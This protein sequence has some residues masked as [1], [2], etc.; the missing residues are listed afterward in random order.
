[1]LTTLH[2]LILVAA[3]WYCAYRQLSFWLWAP[4]LTILLSVMTYFHLLSTTWSLLCWLI[5][6]CSLLLFGVPLIRHA[7]LSKP[8]LAFFRRVLPPMSNTEKEALA[9]GDVWWDKDLFCGRPNWKKFLAM[10][11]PRLQDEEQAFL[12]NQVETLCGMLDD[13]NIVQRDNDLPAEVWAYIKKERFFGMII[14]KTYGGLGFSALAHSSIITKLATRSVS[15]AVNV[16]VPNSLG[17]G[18]LLMHYGTEAQKNHYL[19]RLSC[20]LEIPCFALTGNEAGSDAAA[21]TDTGIVTKGI[22]EGEEVLGIRLNWDKRYI[23]LAP[24]ATLLG[25]AFK[26]YD[27]DHLLGEQTDLGITV[28]LIATDQPG[29][30]IGRRHCPLGMAFMNGPTQGHDVFVP[31]DAIIGGPAMAGQGWRM[32]MECL[33]VGRGISLPALSAADGQLTYQ[34]TGIYARLRRQFKLPI[35]HFEG[36]AMAMG[37]VAGYSYLLNACRILTASAVDQGIKP[38]VASA[39][40]KY[41]MTET[42]RK[43]LNDAMDIHAG[44]GIQLGPRNYLGHAYQAVPVAI[45]VE[46]A[47]ILTRNLMIFGQGAMRCHPFIR[48]EMEAAA[49]PDLN[50]GFKAFDQLLVSHIGYAVSNFFRAFWMGLSAGKW[51]EGAPVNG[52]T[53]RYYQQLTRM[54]TALAFVS[55]ISLLALGGELKRKECLSARLGDVLS[56]LYLAS[57]ALK[58][59]QDLQAQPDDLPYLEWVLQTCLFEIQQAFEGFFDNFPMRGLAK[60]LR[61]VIMPYGRSYKAPSDRLNNRL[62]M[63]MMEASK[64]RDRLTHLCYVGTKPTDPLRRM[65]DAF[66]LALKVEPLRQKCQAALKSRLLTKTTLLSDLYAQALTLNLLTEAE[67]ASLQAADAACQDAM[68]VDDFAPHAFAR[69]DV[70]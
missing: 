31:I 65:E 27:P 55:D 15:A 61:F 35:G 54:S 5:L 40:A 16:M 7:F 29:V 69:A 52:P 21:M 38:S 26:L 20:G 10:P 1:M 13:W 33:S 12:N 59:F 28:C 46:G 68:H 14:P 19:P 64:L 60:A 8:M 23:T 41:H 57:A 50:A 24:I 34:T 58:Y 32:L 25:L 44:R 56:Q 4:S 22:Y 66:N 36:V 11:K 9:A 49:N 51:V 30:A 48:Y 37:R 2:L 70:H 45:T 17:P 42:L 39:I 53:T 63:H 67:V 3:M 43:G 62:A 6:A 47:N 18:E